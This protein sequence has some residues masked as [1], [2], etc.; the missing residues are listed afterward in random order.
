[1]RFTAARSPE[2][3]N[4]KIEGIC[5]LHISRSHVLEGNPDEAR[6]YLQKWKKLPAIEHKNLNELALKV[7]VEVDQITK[8]FKIDSESDELKYEVQNQA[9]IRF[10]VA[11]AH[12][13][14]SG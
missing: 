11:V 14:I 4:E 3:Q 13:K 7:K 1:V 9:L 8:R 6:A 2:S 10:L 5:W 12:T